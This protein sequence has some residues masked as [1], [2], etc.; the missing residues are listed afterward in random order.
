MQAARR[1]SAV[2][3]MHAGRAAN[4][5]MDLRPERHVIFISREPK[6]KYLNFYTATEF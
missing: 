2:I 4:A 6:T 5:D 1:V 3:H